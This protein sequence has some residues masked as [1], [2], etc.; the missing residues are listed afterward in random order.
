M[1]WRNYPR[2][3][4]DGNLQFLLPEGINELLYNPMLTVAYRAVSNFIVRL[5]IF[6]FGLCAASV[7]ARTEATP[8]PVL[9]NTQTA[10]T[11]FA[12][13]KDRCSLGAPGVLA[14][15]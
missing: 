6:P 5:H 2:L 8:S 12:V 15:K 10:W 14:V 7:M 4:F 13:N 3:P 11:S 9:A 1:V